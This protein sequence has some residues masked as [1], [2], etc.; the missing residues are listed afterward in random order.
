MFNGLKMG[1]LPSLLIQLCIH[2]SHLIKVDN[3]IFV[4]KFSKNVKSK[5]YHIENSKTRRQKANYEPPHQDLRCL[6]I[7]LFSSLV[8]INS[9]YYRKD[10]VLLSY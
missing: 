9:D 6:Q 5:L 4:C 2:I 10:T 3:K 8:S 7:Q 1:F